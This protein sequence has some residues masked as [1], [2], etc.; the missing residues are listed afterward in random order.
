MQN[1]EDLI[2]GVTPTTT[3]REEMD[4]YNEVPSLSQLLYTEE[5]QQLVDELNA[6]DIKIYETEPDINQNRYTA[7]VEVATRHGAVDQLKDIPDPEENEA[8]FEAAMAELEQ[9]R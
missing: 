7:L 9:L 1:H 6:A 5:Y 4:E 8:G 2:A 3:L